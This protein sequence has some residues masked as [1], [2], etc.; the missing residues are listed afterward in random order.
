MVAELTALISIVAILFVTN[1]GI[2]RKPGNI[3]YYIKKITTDRSKFFDEYRLWVFL[4]SFI[5]WVLLLPSFYILRG[6]IPLTRYLVPVFPFL[7]LSTVGII[8]YGNVNEEGSYKRFPGKSNIILATGICGVVIK[9]SI[10]FFLVYPH[11][12]NF[13]KDYDEAVL[14]TAQWLRDNTPMETVVATRDIGG[15]AYVSMRKVCDL[16]GLVTPAVLVYR[17]ES[18]PLDL[19]LKGLLPCS[20]KP[21]YFL[22]AEQVDSPEDNLRSGDVFLRR[23]RSAVIRNQGLSFTTS[24]I[25]TLYAI[26]HPD[27]ASSTFHDDPQ[28]S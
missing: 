12:M 25:Y 1:G 22:D 13:S 23:I 7:I 8:E 5:V 3:K 9:I 28:Y 21:E 24:T 4:G 26:E 16:G 27:R 19:V 18:T 10:L 6:A 15:I 20:P 2:R 14:G 11:V 17:D